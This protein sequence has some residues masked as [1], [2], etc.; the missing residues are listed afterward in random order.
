[1]IGGDSMYIDVKGISKILD[2]KSDFIWHHLNYIESIN[3]NIDFND[4]G[5]KVSYLE[6]QFLIEEK[7]KIRNRVLIRFSEVNDFQV[8]NIGGSYNQIMGF[9]IID[10]KGKGWGIDR[11]F[12][13]RDYENEVIKFYCKSIEIVLVAEM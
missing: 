3:Y 9:E 12:L 10:Q 6:I 4:V 1:M 8:K 2:I 5:D 11:R 7:N 13:I